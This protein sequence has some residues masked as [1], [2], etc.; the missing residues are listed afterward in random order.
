MKKLFILSLLSGLLLAAAWPTYGLP[1]LIFFGF[2]PLLI[3]EK[4]IRTST[5]P[6]KWIRV[7][8][9]SY[10][11]FVVWNT[12]TTWWLWNSSVFGMFFAILVNAFLMA[13]VFSIFHFVARKLPAKIHLVFLPAIW[14][15]FEKFHLNWPFSWPWLNL[16]NVFS[17]YYQWIQW[18][19]YTGVFGGSLWIWIVNIGVF[20]IWEKYLHTKNIKKVM[21][22]AGIQLA[23]VILPVI[24][25][26]W[27]FATYQNT[28][29]T[30]TVIVLQPNVDPYTEKY[31]RD[32]IET[33]S[34]LLS[35]TQVHDVTEID[36][37]IAPE[38]TLSRMTPMDQFVFTREYALIRSLIDTHPKVN[39]LTGADMFRL[40]LQ[41]ERPTPFANRTSR[42]DWADYFNTAV[43]IKKNAPPE[44]YIKSKLVVGVETLP[45]KNF[46]EP[47][48]GNIM[49]DL[50]GTIATRAIQENRTVFTSA[51][52][53]YKAGPIICYESVYGEFVTEYIKEG[54]NFLAI[55]TNDGWWGTTQGHKQHLSYSRLRAIETRRSIARSANTGISAIINPKGEIVRSLGYNQKGSVM[56]EVTLN[57]KHT[58]YVKYG[59]YI[60]RIAVLLSVLLLLFAIARKKQ[61]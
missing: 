53:N 58:V 28:G 9:Y 3:V 25:S 11:S 32:N 18:Y 54:A 34:E 6:R 23:W 45:F 13:F 2:L 27:M 41:S 5:E 14:I 60:A 48:L 4:K 57:E 31:E 38:T 16:G 22:A 56:G 61:V 26:L 51:D 49:L 52:G 15:A 8:L 59:D 21:K 43:F 36:F 20:R 55:I 47:V 44:F 42:G 24:I 29:N 12:I 39:F 46:L 7:L 50:G 17:E 37:V 30:A 33:V 10:I 19:E 35:L 40:Y 1:F